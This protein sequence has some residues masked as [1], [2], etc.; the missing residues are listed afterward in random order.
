MP[1]DLETLRELFAYNRWATAKILD[2][3]APLS[4]EEFARPIGGSF[5]SIHGTLAHVYGAEW[6][7][8]ERF[9]GRSP[10]SLPERE[11]GSTLQD[12]QEKWPTGRGGP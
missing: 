3:V 1:F 12:F 10:R 11:E 5:G 9:R 6:V 4:E 7:W 2:C 8:L